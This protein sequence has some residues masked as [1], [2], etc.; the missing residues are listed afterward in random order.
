VARLCLQSRTRGHFI[1][2]ESAE[3]V[4]QLNQNRHSRPIYRCSLGQFMSVVTALIFP[5]AAGC[6]NLPSLDV[7][8]GRL[9]AYAKQYQ[10]ALPSLSCDEQ[11]TSQALNKKGKV[12]SEVKASQPFARFVPRIHTIRFMKSVTSKA[13]TG[14]VPAGRF[15]CRTLSRGCKSCRFQEVG[16]EGVLLIM[17]LL[18]GTAA[19]P[20]Y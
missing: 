17:F 8:L 20:S 13:S 10:A 9:D 5:A 2:A 19:R 12:T 7:L 4:E 11:I 3:M 16:A 14:T 18:P 1:V 6:Q 15:K